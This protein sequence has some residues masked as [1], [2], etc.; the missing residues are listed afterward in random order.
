MPTSVLAGD[1]QTTVPKEV[2]EALHLQ[3]GDN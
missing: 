3:E 1:G 2:R